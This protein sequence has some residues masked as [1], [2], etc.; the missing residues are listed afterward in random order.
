MMT[1]QNTE[2]YTDQQLNALNKEFNE[3]FQAGEWGPAGK[4]EAEK[5]FA[6]E[7]ARRLEH[8]PGPWSCWNGEINGIGQNSHSYDEGIIAKMPN[9]SS[10]KQQANARLIIA[11]HDLLEACKVAKANL[12]HCKANIVN[13][14]EYFDIVVNTL[15]QAIT[16]AEGE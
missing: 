8:T 10:F 11:V 1:Q 15:N 3:R 12:I 16:K 13:Y 6:D 2:G 14:P 4:D 7:V 9:M 5:W